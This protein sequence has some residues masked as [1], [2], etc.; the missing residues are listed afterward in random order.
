M[1]CIYKSN[2]YCLPLL[3]VVGTTCLNGTYYVAF[4]FLLQK[5]KEDFTW[6]LTILRSLYR[7]LDLEDPKVI[8]TDRDIAVMAAIHEI[9]PRTTNLLCLWHL[10][11]CVQ[12]EWKPIFQD[13]GRPEEE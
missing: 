2:K 7:R 9:F 8:V 6:F 4:G 5:K 3:N 12:S 13:S 10:N 11:K 1:D